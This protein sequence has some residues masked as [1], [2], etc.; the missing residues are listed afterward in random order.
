[1]EN[2]VHYYHDGVLV[3]EYSDMYRPCIGEDVEI[4]YRKFKVISVRHVPAQNRV[5]INLELVSNT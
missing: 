2:F 3:G 4:G 5:A 1:M